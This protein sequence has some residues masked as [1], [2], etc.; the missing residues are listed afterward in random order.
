MQPPVILR[1]RVAGEIG[2][3]NEVAERRTDVDVRVQVIKVMTFGQV[4]ARGV[5]VGHGPLNG[6]NGRILVDVDPLRGCKG[7]QPGGVPLAA[8]EQRLRRR[9]WLRWIRAE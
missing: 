2:R 7:Q 1:G 8:V 5:S 4:P 6:S 3:R 9:V